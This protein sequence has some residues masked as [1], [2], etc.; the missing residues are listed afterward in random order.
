MPEIEKQGERRGG[1]AQE[2]LC[3]CVYVCVCVCVCKQGGVAGA[4]QAR[5]GRKASERRRQGGEGPILQPL[6]V[7]KSFRE[8]L[9]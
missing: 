5:V 6:A 2:K 3:V 1:G 4:G 9:G 7:D 8:A